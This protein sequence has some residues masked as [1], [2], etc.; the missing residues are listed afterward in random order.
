MKDFRIVSTAS[1]KAYT[2]LPSSTQKSLRGISQLLSLFS[3]NLSLPTILAI[4]MF[5]QLTAL[6]LLPRYVASTP[7]IIF[8][9]YKMLYARPQTIADNWYLNGAKLGRHSAQVP[10][11]D[12]SLPEKPGSNGVVCFVLGS[13]VNQ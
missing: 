10:N 4:G 11:E 7:V 9:V 3:H 12:G 6:T 2:L 5:V 8:I 13:E 1:S